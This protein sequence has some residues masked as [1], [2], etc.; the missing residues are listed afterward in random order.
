MKK[1]IIITVL[2]A[3]C[4]GARAQYRNVFVEKGYDKAQVETRLK[5]VFDDVFRGPNKVYFEVGD[6]MGYVSDI[7]NHDVRTEG[8]SYGMMIAVQFGEKDIFDRLWRW[9]KKY[10]QHQDG[11]RKGYFAW[12][13]KTDG[14]RNA[15]GAASDGELYFITALLF[16][17][18]R[19][20]NDTGIN[21]KKE[22]QFI[23]DCIQP[24][25]YT[26]APRQGG[27][28][29]FG[30][31][32]GQQG[33]QKMYLI[34]PETKLITF[35][36]DGFGQ[37]F[38]DP[39]Y[40]IPAFYE[41]WAK[42]ADDGRS[43][44]WQSCAD[45]SRA[46]LHK[47]INEE[48]GLNPDQCNFD[49]TIQDSPF[50][51]GKSFMYDSWRVPMNIALDYSWACK[52][53]EWQ[54]KYANTIQNFFYKQGVKTFKDQYNVDGTFPERPMSAGGKTALRHSVGLVG[55]VAAISLA[56]NNPHAIE[57]VKELWNSE[58]KPFEDGYFDAYYDGLLRLF[59]FM[60]LSG[61]YRVIEPVK[62]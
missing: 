9:S 50:P 56:S 33:P 3:M 12:S 30:G 14:T 16:A 21:Y 15:E 45:S 2:M 41:V 23:L 35:T 19:W 53:K 61:K 10:M 42:W 62:K 27:F 48:T 47:C 59:A 31:F 28:P 22:A 11:D 36:P 25:E 24:K 52:D 29:G 1:L 40:H 32:G 37:R 4:A 17:S 54:Q 8:M 49:G 6:S 43:E 55:T 26:P 60:H 39:S 44:Y 18:N 20:G 58:N 34:D 5:Q 7:K 57:F 38:T 13:L 46:F 51:W